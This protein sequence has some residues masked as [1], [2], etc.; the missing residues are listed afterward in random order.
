MEQLHKYDPVP[1]II[2]SSPAQRWRDGG[3]ETEPD[4]VTLLSHPASKG[5]VGRQDGGLNPKCTLRCFLPAG[6]SRG[7]AFTCAGETPGLLQ[8]AALPVCRQRRGK[9]DFCCALLATEHRYKP[10]GPGLLPSPACAAQARLTHTQKAFL[11]PAVAKKLCRQGGRWTS[12][13][14]GT[15]PDHDCCV[16][17]SSG[18]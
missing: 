8:A 18:V 6:H 11:S 9:A 7:A 12:R 16:G 10:W 14:G 13:P 15:S 1:E 5:L 17:S 4:P 2:T 3:A